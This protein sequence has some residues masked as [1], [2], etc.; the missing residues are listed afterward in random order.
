MVSEVGRAFSIEE[1]SRPGAPVVVRYGRAGSRGGSFERRGKGE[2]L[3]LSK[4]WQEQV[5]QELDVTTTGDFPTV[6]I[7]PARLATRA[8]DP[9][10]TT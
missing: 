2:Q 5:V 3:D 10:Q 6:E 7:D 4:P 9:P 1:S 8:T